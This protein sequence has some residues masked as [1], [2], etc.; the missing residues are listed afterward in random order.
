M[1]PEN[2]LEQRLPL[3]QFAAV[4]LGLRVNWPVMK[5]VGSPPMILVEEEMGSS[6][7]LGPPGPL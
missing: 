2:A 1:E 7:W 3:W 4:D 5:G 6:S